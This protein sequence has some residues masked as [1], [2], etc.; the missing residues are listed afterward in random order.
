MKAE[1]V[2][3]IKQ[4]DKPAFAV[5]P[6]D[7]YVEL[8]QSGKESGSFTPINLRTDMPQEVLDF[9]NSGYSLIASWR[10]YK[11][12]S[13]RALAKMLG[14]KQPAVCQIERP[15]STPQPITLSKVAKAL[16]ISISQLQS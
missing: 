4:G 8:V 2:H 13:Q 6:Y 11:G 5:L 16:G 7:Y 10:M 3:I 12:I 14:V 9:L 15:N 1:N